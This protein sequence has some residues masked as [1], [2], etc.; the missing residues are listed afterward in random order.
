MTQT[1]TKHAAR[2]LSP[3]G[4]HCVAGLLSRGRS[5]LKKNDLSYS[6][7]PW[8][9]SS[10]DLPRCIARATCSRL[11]R[12]ACRPRVCQQGAHVCW[13]STYRSRGTTRWWWVVLTGTHALAHTPGT[14][15]HTHT[16]ARARTHT[17]TQARGEWSGCVRVRVQRL[18]TPKPHADIAGAAL[19]RSMHRFGFR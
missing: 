17:H 7:F 1:K 15:A 18:H 5:F 16:H 13:R 4:V 8:H 3:Y 19:C 2:Y 9:S 14:P 12:A 10:W 11:P 6:L